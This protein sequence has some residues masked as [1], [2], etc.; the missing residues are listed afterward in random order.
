MKKNEGTKKT[1]KI[2]RMKNNEEEWTRI[3][4]KKKE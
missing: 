4:K 1:N 2:R 3:K